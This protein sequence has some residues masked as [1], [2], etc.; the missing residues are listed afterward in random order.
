LGQGFPDFNGDPVA[1]QRACEVIQEDPRLNQY[2][3]VNGIL[4]LRQSLSQF[5][6]RS[7]PHS[8]VLDANTEIVVTCSGTEAIQSAIHT[9]VQPGDEVIVFDPS[10]PW[11]APDIRVAGGIVKSVSLKF[12]DFS[13]S[14]TQLRAQFSNKTKVVIVNSPHNPTGHVLRPE[15]ATLIAKLCVEH[16]CF[17]ISDEVYEHYIFSSSLSHVRMCDQEGML[18]RTLTIGSA[19]KM[20][21]LTGW[22][23]GWLFGPAALIAPAKTLH[24]FSSYCAPTPFQD[25]VRAALDHA[26]SQQPRPNPDGIE[27]LNQR[28]L[29]NAQRLSKA[30]ETLEVYSVL[31]EGGYF[32]VCDVSATGKSDVEFCTFLAKEKGVVAVPM[33]VFFTG[34]DKPTNLVRFAICKTDEVIDRAIKAILKN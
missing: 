30:L 9:L 21:S 23:V 16:D 7:Y 6:S 34:E 1:R 5:I 28:F 19:S 13:I 26:A 17:C 3:L 11:Y 20:F 10:F 2:S 27:V 12:P 14:E 15:E 8:P 4:P 22:R 31:P 24:S 32:L 29:K 18:E 25:G 33:T